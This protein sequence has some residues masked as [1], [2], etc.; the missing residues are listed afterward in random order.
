M[1][2]ISPV[3]KRKVTKDNFKNLVKQNSVLVDIKEAYM[4]MKKKQ[5]QKNLAPARVREITNKEEEKCI[6]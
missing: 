6:T 4:E 5:I 1:N 3:Y 2:Q